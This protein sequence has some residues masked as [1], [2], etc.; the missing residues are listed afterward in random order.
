MNPQDMFPEYRA[1]L[2][3]ADS[4]T[5][6]VQSEQERLRAGGN[7]TVVQ[8]SSVKR[9]RGHLQLA[10]EALGQPLDGERD[11]QTSLPL[12]GYGAGDGWQP[13][14]PIPEPESEAPTPVPGDEATPASA[15][16]EATAPQPSP[17]L[18]DRLDE[19]GN[20]LEAALGSG[21]DP[22][23]ENPVVEGAAC[24]AA[25][26]AP[27]FVGRTDVL[28]IPDLV[29]FFQLQAKTGVLTIEGRDETFRLEF[30]EG[31]LI[32]AAS[33]DSPPGERLG[34]ILQRRGTITRPRLHALLQQ[35]GQDEKLGDALLR[36]E[37][38]SSDDLAAALQEQ[39]LGIFVRLA[40]LPGCHFTFREGGVDPDVGDHVRYNVTGLL[41][42]SARQIDEARESA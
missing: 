14:P 4:I 9:A 7:V 42:D 12:P 18:Q 27:E 24:S 39:V 10:L 21:D 5:H 17:W 25:N 19:I 8:S 11:P 1:L 16:A 32:H 13:L 2:A 15:P 33:S 37:D 36:A 22:F 41:L 23:A 40:Q 30:N 34:E 6:R 29:G 26:K 28:S 38:V 20:A 3:L 35:L 31:A